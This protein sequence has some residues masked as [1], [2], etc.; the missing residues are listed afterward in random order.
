V[1]L[2]MKNPPTASVCH[3]GGYVLYPGEA[4]AGEAM[5][6]AG[7]GRLFQSITGWRRIF[8]FPLR[9]TMQWR[10]AHLAAA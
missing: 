10:L 6:M 2:K 4:G 3:G 1:V 7:Y 5:L 9:S 8:P